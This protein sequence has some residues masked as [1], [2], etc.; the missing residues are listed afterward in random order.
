M[1]LFSFHTKMPVEKAA[2]EM[3]EKGLDKYFQRLCNDLEVFSAH[4]SRKTVKPE[5][6]ELLMRR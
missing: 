4:A 1:K 5:D 6:L 2:L 3:V